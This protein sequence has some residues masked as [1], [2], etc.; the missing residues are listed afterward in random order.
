MKWKK[1]IIVLFS[2]LFAMLL[3]VSCGDCYDNVEKNKSKSEGNEKVNQNSKYD[4]KPTTITIMSNL[5][6]PKVPNDRILEILEEKT[7]VELEI[8]WVPDNNYNEKLNTAFA[9]GTLPQVM[10]VGFE[11][12][13]QFK[14]AIRDDQFW[15]IGPYIEEFENLSKLKEPVLDRKSFV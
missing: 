14:E 8:D 10:S 2:I 13:D 3:F 1:R 9:T 15:E 7:N 11:Q 6:T 5:H 4:G 12:M